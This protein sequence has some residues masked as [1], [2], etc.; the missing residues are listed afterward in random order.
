[1]ANVTVRIARFALRFELSVLAIGLSLRNLLLRCFL[2]ILVGPVALL[3]CI[4][5]PFLKLVFLV[6]TNTCFNFS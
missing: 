6:H 3:C 2:R 1:M 4:L 5:V